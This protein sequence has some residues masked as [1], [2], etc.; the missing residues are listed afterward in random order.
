MAI[1]YDILKVI[2]PRISVEVKNAWDV[3]CSCIND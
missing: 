1:V 2:C 3:F